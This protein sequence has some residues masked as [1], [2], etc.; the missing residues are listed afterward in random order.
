M[1]RTDD[2]SGGGN[3]R[4]S[5]QI[6]YIKI[7]SLRG[8]LQWPI[9]VFGLVTARDVLDNRRHN[10]IFARARSKSQTIT[11]EVIIFLHASILF[12]SAHI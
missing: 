8:G 2:P 4:E 7:A 11:E 9:D 1:S 10:V 3:T 5:L 12:P 6:V